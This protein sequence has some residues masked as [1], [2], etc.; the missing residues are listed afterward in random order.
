MCRRSVW[1]RKWTCSQ[2]ALW[3]VV[4]LS[5]SVFLV[6]SLH[7]LRKGRCQRCHLLLGILS[8]VTF[9]WPIISRCSD[10]TS[11]QRHV[12]GMKDWWF[13]QI[14]FW[15]MTFNVWHFGRVCQTSTNSLVSLSNL[16]HA[17]P[18]H[19]GSPYTDNHLIYGSVVCKE[20]RYMTGTYVN[21]R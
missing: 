15:R 1:Q 11:H 6:L 21:T 19:S 12:F 14:G 5:D 7:L 4:G 9:P 8:V 2:G 3:F 17:R 20:V 16:I 10:P 18:P 13:L